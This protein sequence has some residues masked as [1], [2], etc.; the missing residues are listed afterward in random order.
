MERDQFT[1]YRSFWEALKALPKKDQLPFVMAVCSYAL[2]GESKPLSGAPYASFL[3]VKPILDKASKKAASG[4]RGGSKQKANGKQNVSKPEQNAS[5]IEGEKEKEG[6]REREEEDDNPPTPLAVNIVQ[7]SGAVKDFLDRVNPQTPYPM[8]QELAEYEK[9]LGTAV[10]KRAFDVALAEKK[11]NWSYVR[12]ILRNCQARGILCLADWDELEKE[13][14]NQARP[15]VKPQ[16][17][18]KSFADL[19]AELEGKL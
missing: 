4:K 13:R 16:S 9:T 8:L 15:C 12:G 2:D 7:T 18:G 17:G 14:E 5:H 1:F 6:E 3:L 19:A 10:C 11:T